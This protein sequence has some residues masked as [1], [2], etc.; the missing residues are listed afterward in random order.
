MNAGSGVFNVG[1]D[2]PR[3]VTSVAVKIASIL[4]REVN[5]ISSATAV[6]QRTPVMFPAGRVDFDD[7]L[8]RTVRWYQ[9]HEREF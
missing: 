9:E 7:G 1:V 8:S 5:I 3:S 2:D 6:S 4:G